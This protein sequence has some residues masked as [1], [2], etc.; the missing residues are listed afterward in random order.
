RLGDRDAADRS[1]G[2]A[3][4]HLGGAPADPEWDI[5]IVGYSH[6]SDS[7]DSTIFGPSHSDTSTDSIAIP[8]VGVIAYLRSTLSDC[9]GQQA[10]TPRVGFIRSQNDH[11]VSF[12]WGHGDADSKCCRQPNFWQR[13]G[14]RVRP[15]G[16]LMAWKQAVRGFF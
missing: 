9:T 10:I 11:E 3:A 14:P 4:T 13:K 7:S 5:D 8:K 2:G 1:G 12:R 15:P 6:L 16:G